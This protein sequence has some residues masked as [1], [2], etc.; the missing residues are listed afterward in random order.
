[1]LTVISGATNAV[2]KQVPFGQNGAY[3][4]VDPDTNRVFTADGTADYSTAPRTPRREKSL[5][6]RMELV[7]PITGALYGTNDRP[8]RS[9][10]WSMERTRPTTRRW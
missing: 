8:V 9:S 5:S 3:V 6:K 2:T 10:M 1:M 7:N 4:A